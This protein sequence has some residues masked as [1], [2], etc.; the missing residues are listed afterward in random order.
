MTLIIFFPSVQL[1]IYS[2]DGP[3]VRFVEE[4]PGVVQTGLG[5]VRVG[6]QPYVRAVQVSIMTSFVIASS[7]SI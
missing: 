5:A 3:A 2:P 1:S 6:L 4:Q 7:V